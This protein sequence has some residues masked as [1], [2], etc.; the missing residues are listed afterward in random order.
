MT[1]ARTGRP[2]KPGGGLAANLNVRLDRKTYDNLGAAAAA[3]G[4]ANRSQL[5]RSLIDSALEDLNRSGAAGTL[6]TRNRNRNP[7]KQP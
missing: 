3:A 5:V 7:K 6:T 2:K 4:H 1:S